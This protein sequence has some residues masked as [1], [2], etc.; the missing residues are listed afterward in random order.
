MFICHPR[1]HCTI[2]MNSG[3][4]TCVVKLAPSQSWKASLY[5]ENPPFVRCTYKNTRLDMRLSGFQNIFGTDCIDSL[6]DYYAMNKYNSSKKYRNTHNGRMHTRDAILK[7]RTKNIENAYRC[8][9]RY[10]KEDLEYFDKILSGELTIS[11]VAVALERSNQAIQGKL[12]K[13][14]QSM[15]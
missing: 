5:R 4:N 3:N 15:C 14:R 7:Y 2:T 11:E 10:T 9:D 1:C 12:H 6:F 8:G 13:I